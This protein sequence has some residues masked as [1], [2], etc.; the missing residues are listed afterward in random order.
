MHKIV[1]IVGRAN[2]GKSRLF[3]RMVGKRVAIVGDRPGVT[4]DRSYAV[5]EWLDLEYILV[6]TGGIDLD[7]ETDLETKVT[8]QSL[9]GCC[10]SRY[11]NLRL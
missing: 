3:N 10:G 1:A 2:V 6:D 11:C 8:E 4:R 7:P 5:A 9:K